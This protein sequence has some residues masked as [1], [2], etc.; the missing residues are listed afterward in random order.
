M[1]DG[2]PRAVSEKYFETVCPTE[3][4]M[5]LSSKDMDAPTWWEGDELIRWWT[6]KL[7]RHK[8]AR[9]LV[10]DTTERIIFDRQ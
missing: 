5:I 1:P 9:C 4:R 3:K 8:D 2:A 7:E 6:E 10:I